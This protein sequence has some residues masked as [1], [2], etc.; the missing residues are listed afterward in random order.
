MKEKKESLFK[1]IGGRKTLQ[2]VHKLFYDKLFLHPWLKLFF[3]DTFRPQIENQQTDFMTNAMGGFILF[4]GKP[5][6]PTHINMN[7]TTEIF[8]LRHNILKETI[9]ECG[10]ND[11]LAKEWLKIDYAFRAAI[12]KKDVSECIKKHDNDKILDFKK[13]LNA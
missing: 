11:K 13:P 10:V 6:I 9:L 5:P 8:D 3:Q 4:V 12:C 7:I 1:R 2:K